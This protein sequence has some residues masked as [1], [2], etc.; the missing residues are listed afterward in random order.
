MR[1]NLIYLS[2]LTLCMLMASA[3]GR[4]EKK[5]NT[6]TAGTFTMFCDDS[7]ENIM[8]QEID[9]FEYQYPDVHVLA[10]YGTEAEAIDSITSLNTKTIVIPRELT[11]AEINRIK[12]KKNLPV[13]QSRI[14]VDAIALIVNKDNPCDNISIGE[15][16]D[17]LKGTTSN[18]MDLSPHFPDK[19]I[20]VLFDN[21][22]SSMVAYMRDSLING[23]QLGP[24]SYAQGSIA[25]VLDGVRKDPKA[26]GVIGVSW[27]TP[28]LREAVPIDTLASQLQDE[29]SGASM[30][31]IN[32]QIELS[33]VKVLG[34]RTVD[35][36]YPYRPFQQ[37]IYN[38]TYP[39]TRSIYM[40]TCAP[41]GPARGFYSFVT[42]YIGQKL[43]MKTGVMPARMSVQV[44][45]LVP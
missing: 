1:R 2:V 43:I 23:E 24:N 38:G 40:I 15:L 16:S 10:R 20:A 19:P 11:Q 37:N 13:V 42:G 18:W 5:E 30:D 32:K 35:N 31:E 12:S 33:G 45:E 14:A 39:L 28:D 6:A 34:L 27:L 41:G 44:V 3:C 29:T 36:P 8:E 22:G 21:A 7:F 26:I 17:I 25:A 4:Y 9:V